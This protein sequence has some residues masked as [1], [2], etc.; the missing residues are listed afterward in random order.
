MTTATPPSPLRNR[1]TFQPRPCRVAV[2][3]IKALAESDELSASDEIYLITVASLAGAGGA[4]RK[5]LVANLRND[6]ESALRVPTGMP[7]FDNQVGATQEL[8]LTAKHVALTV[9][10]APFEESV[11]FF[12]GNEGEGHFRVDFVFTTGKA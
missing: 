5:A 12:G 2:E 9:P 11:Y 3:G 10:G 4:S 7:D 6:I 1:L 8:R